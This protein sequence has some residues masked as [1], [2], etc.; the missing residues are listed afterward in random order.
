MKIYVVKETSVGTE[1]NPNFAG[2]IEVSF[3][4]IGDNLIL[5]RDYD[6][7]PEWFIREFGYIRKCDAKRNWAYKN[8]ENDNYWQSVVE[9]IEFDI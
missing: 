7:L 9:I 3:H 4:D 8:P 2:K 6:G 1:E 5:A